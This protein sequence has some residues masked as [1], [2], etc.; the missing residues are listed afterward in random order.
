VKAKVF[1]AYTTLILTFMLVCVH[2]Q[3]LTKGPYTVSATREDGT[4]VTAKDDEA[5]VTILDGSLRI[6]HHIDFANLS[7]RDDNLKGY[8][9]LSSWTAL[10][11]INGNVWK[12]QADAGSVIETA[13]DPTGAEN[14]KYIPLALAPGF[15]GKLHLKKGESAVI[16]GETY[17]AENEETLELSWDGIKAQ[18]PVS[19][20]KK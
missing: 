17:T 3:T 7:I 12:I 11:R 13:Y 2:S 10:E 8:R 9:T 14:K 20:E 5:Y 4:R 15:K 6:N 18:K 1:V 19:P 16:L